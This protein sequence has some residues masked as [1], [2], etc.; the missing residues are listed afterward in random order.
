MRSTLRA[1]ALA[2][3]IT[4]PFIAGPAPALAGA[5]FSCSIRPDYPHRSKTPTD[6]VAKAE[7][8][9]D[10]PITSLTYTLRLQKKSSSR[11]WTTVRTLS[12][13][14]LGPSIWANPKK[15]IV[16]QVA[17]G[18]SRG[19]FRTAVQL[20]NATDHGQ[21]KVGNVGYSGVVMDPCVPTGGGGGGW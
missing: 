7:L 9:C 1:F 15:P 12:E 14:L 20:N 3:L 19:Q 16:R 10:R 6:I 11:G 2:A 8:G 5:P 17:I 4:V 21:T 18:C 13:T